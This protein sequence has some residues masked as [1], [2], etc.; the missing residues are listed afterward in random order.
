MQDL[1]K[2]LR[3][4]TITFLFL[5]ALC[6]PLSISSSDYVDR[7]DCNMT[8]PE[9]S[10]YWVAPFIAEFIKNNIELIDESCLNYLKE[11]TLMEI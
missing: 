3:F 10:E 8:P 11:N 9:G 1:L 7:L 6:S 5:L 2:D 4:I